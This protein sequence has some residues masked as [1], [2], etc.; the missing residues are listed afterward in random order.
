MSV[1]SAS[2]SWFYRPR[3]RVAVWEGSRTRPMTAL[4]GESFLSCKLSDLKDSQWHQ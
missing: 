3:T 1:K 2:N 4:H